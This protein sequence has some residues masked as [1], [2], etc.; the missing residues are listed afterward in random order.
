MTGNQ[1]LDWNASK[2][3]DDIEFQE[4]DKKQFETLLKNKE[5]KGE[6]GSI[7]LMTVGE[8]LTGKIVEISKDFVVVDV[9]LKSEGLVPVDEFENPEELALGNEIEVYLAQAEGDNGQIVLSREKARRLR[10]WQYIVDHCDE[11]SLLMAK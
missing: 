9:G 11:G 2:I 4:E 1:N 5:A 3:I 8:I 10:Q 7:S 6:E